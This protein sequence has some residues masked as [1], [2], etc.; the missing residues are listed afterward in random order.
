MALNHYG[1]LF[2]PFSNMYAMGS[3]CEGTYTDKEKLQTA[4]YEK[5]ARQLA[6]NLITAA[7]IA[8]RQDDY[9]WTY[10]NSAD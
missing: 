2:P 8:K 3:V 7:R 10:D 6:Q 1:L 4:C 5:E 9:W